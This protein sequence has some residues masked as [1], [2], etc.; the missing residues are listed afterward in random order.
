M[1]IKVDSGKFQFQYIPDYANYL[2]KNK[3]EEFTTVGIR[4]CREADL[5]MMRAVAKIPE[6]DLVALSVA[7]NKELLA[8]LADNNVA[9]VVEKNL[10]TFIKNEMVDKD[11][12]KILDRSEI[13]A[14]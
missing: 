3:L 5:P 9:S 6:K 8:A 4:F 7:A 12:K 2:L 14:E 10:T 11:G 1:N 13:M